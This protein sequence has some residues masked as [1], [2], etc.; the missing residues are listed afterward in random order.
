[1]NNEYTQ[2]KRTIIM[3]IPTDKAKHQY[4][5][6]FTAK[7]QMPVLVPVH[8]HWIPTEPSGHFPIVAL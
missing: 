4:L 8:A 5:N 3:G 2:P 7:K 1:M 6:T